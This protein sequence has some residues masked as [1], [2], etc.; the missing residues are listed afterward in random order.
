MTVRW[1]K[2]QEIRLPTDRYRGV[3]FRHHTQASNQFSYPGDINEGTNQTHIGFTHKS[4]FRQYVGIRRPGASHSNN[5]TYCLGIYVNWQVSE[6]VS[7]CSVSFSECY[8]LILIKEGVYLNRCYCD[9]RGNHS[10]NCKPGL[11]DDDRIKD[12]FRDR[13]GNNCR[14][15]INYTIT[16]LGLA[17]TQERIQLCL[18]SRPSFRP[19]LL[20]EFLFV[21][22][23]PIALQL[24]LILPLLLLSLFVV[25]ESPRWLASHAR[26]EE[27][28]HVLRMLYTAPPTSDEPPEA[29]MI[30]NAIID[31]VN[32]DKQFGSEHWG[33]VLRLLKYDDP[34][35]S[36]RRLLIACGIQAFQ[37]LGGIN[38][39]Y[40]RFGFSVHH[41]NPYLITKSLIITLEDRRSAKTIA[42]L[43]T[44]DVRR[45][46]RT[47][48]ST[49]MGI[50]WPASLR[51]S[52][53]SCKRPQGLRLNLLIANR[54]MGLFTIG[55]QAVV[56]VYPSEILPLRFRAKG[57]ALSTARLC[58]NRLLHFPRVQQTKGMS[59]EEINE[60]FS[61]TALV[62]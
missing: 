28:K 35:K 29:D 11:C 1:T 50:S 19:R 43:L 56:W 62:E 48:R 33:D 52:W 42:D 54:F 37:Q 30:F 14:Y 10:S 17:N 9:A 59:L 27:A 55:F 12:S 13:I 36:R 16:T 40:P 57:S 4:L 32:Y 38:C 20:E 22:R 6:D 58:S 31:T 51:P 3:L 18:S 49:R 45:T 41:L 23:I 5:D 61:T 47:S 34:I 7:P 53:F 2:R 44:F 25:P 24:V 39:K 60:L 46:L 15:I 26:T 8:S 21:Y